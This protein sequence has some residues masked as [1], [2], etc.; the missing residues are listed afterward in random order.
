[1]QS[2]TVHLRILISWIFVVM[3]DRTEGGGARAIVAADTIPL[4]HL[5]RKRKII[6]SLTSKLWY[7][8]TKF[9]RS[10]LTTMRIVSPT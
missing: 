6:P 7:N 1:M 5:H 10:L 2:H 8:E 9:A 3:M 4:Q